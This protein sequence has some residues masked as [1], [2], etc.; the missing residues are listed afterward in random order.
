[1]NLSK[2]LKSRHLLVN[3]V[4]ALLNVREDIY[5][6]RDVTHDPLVIINEGLKFKNP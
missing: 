1:M 6:P 5:A 2:S 3:R 4:I